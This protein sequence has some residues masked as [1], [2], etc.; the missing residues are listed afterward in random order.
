LVRTA[1]VFSPPRHGVSLAFSSSVGGVPAPSCVSLGFANSVDPVRAAVV[2]SP[3]HRGFPSRSHTACVQ[4]GWWWCSHR[5]YWPTA[6]V[7]GLV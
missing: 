7:A 5:P 6:A 2:V 4:R 1:V 3:P